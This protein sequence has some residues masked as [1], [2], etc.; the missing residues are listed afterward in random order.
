MPAAPAKVTSGVQYPIVGSI[1][2]KQKVSQ[3][4]A[5]QS[6]A[7]EARKA[8]RAAREFAGLLDDYAKY[9]T[10][11]NFRQRAIDV[12]LSALNKLNIVNEG[13]SVCQK[14]VAE[15]PKAIEPPIKTAPAVET[16]V[17]ESFAVEPPK[18]PR[19]IRVA[20]KSGNR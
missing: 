19:S 18:Q 5:L 17:I 15:S 4:E 7:D 14:F 3:K 10:Q 2:E 16:E 6:A 1:K 20:R 9:L 13:L 12:H 8:A 11:P